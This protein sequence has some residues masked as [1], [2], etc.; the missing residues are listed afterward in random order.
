MNGED[1][2]PEQ[3]IS[4][5]KALKLN[6]LGSNIQLHL[7]H[8]MHEMSKLLSLSVAVSSSVKL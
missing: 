1:S 5:E 3:S 2:K 6:C 8:W 7:T 4:R